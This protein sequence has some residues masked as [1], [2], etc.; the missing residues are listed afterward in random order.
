MMW[1]NIILIIFVIIIIWFWYIQIRKI[2]VKKINL[3]FLPLNLK[4]GDLILFKACDNLNSTVIFNYF[5][6]IGIVVIDPILT[7]NE[8]YLFEA[9]SVK[10][11]NGIRFTPLK[12]R[13]ERY[14]GFT[15][16]KPLS[17]KI[18]NIM[19]LKLINFINYALN[20]MYYNHNIIVS[21]IYKKI[22]N[23]KCDN[24]TNCGEIIFLCLIN[25]GLLN[26]NLWFSRKLHYLKWMCNIKKMNYNYKYLNLIE[27]NKKY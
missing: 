23:I 26:E 13:L 20:N 22:M 12:K 15:Y 7:K 2:D 19:K 1:L 11:N 18:T 14:I 4:T 9:A 5:T 17:K 27:I 21:S 8:P 10:N 25:M 16:Y 3:K 24:S 6:H